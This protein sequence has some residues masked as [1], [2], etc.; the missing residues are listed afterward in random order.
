MRDALIGIAAAAWTAV[1]L[2][3]APGQRDA[4]ATQGGFE[5]G[6]QAAHYRYEE[7][8]LMWLKGDRVG[9]SMSYTALGLSD[10]HARFEGRYSYAQLDYQGSG[11]LLGVPDHLLELRALAGRDY[12]RGRVVWVP[13]AGLGLRYLYNDLRG[14]SSTGAIGYRRRSHYWYVPLGVALRF[15]L[16]ESWVMAPQL[17]YDAFAK[18]SQRSYLDDTGLGIN[19]VTN[20]QQRGGGY[21][22]QLMLEGRRW[23]FGPWMHYWK[24]KDSDIQPIGGGFGGLEPE[25]WTRESGVELRYRF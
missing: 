9:L 5:A 16:G 24:I 3:Q 18:G 10:V 23:T 14:V 17:E 7:P 12:L 22:V 25:N 4:L 6:L 21:R 19:T 20:R 11:T 8:D 2:A 15:A 13:Y 1:S